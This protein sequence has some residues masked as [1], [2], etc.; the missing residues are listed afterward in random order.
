VELVEVDTTAFI[1]KT[2]STIGTGVK[3]SRGVRLTTHPNLV[4]MS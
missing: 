3:G 4:P 2:P 1:I